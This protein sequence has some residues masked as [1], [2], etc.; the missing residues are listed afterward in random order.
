MAFNATATRILGS[1]LCILLVMGSGVAQLVDD[2]RAGACRV[3]DQQVLFTTGE[4]V[5]YLRQAQPG[6]VRLLE[7]SGDGSRV[8]QS[9][10]EY[11]DGHLENV[12]RYENKVWTL[13]DKSGGQP[14]PDW[15]SL[16]KR[17]LHKEAVVYFY[18]CQAGYYDHS[19][20][21]ERELG[22]GIAQAFSAEF[23]VTT[24]GCPEFVFYPGRFPD[25]GGRLFSN[26]SE[27]PSEGHSTPGGLWNVFKDGKRYKPLKS[28]WVT[29]FK[30]LPPPRMPGQTEKI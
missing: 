22:W 14:A 28:D 2:E 17:A 23:G 26:P 21:M 8:Y 18:G 6:S 16:L 27:P 4:L 3:N 12:L 9:L 29:T 30:G 25:P 11:P 7:F 1:L 15:V 13:T 19:G 20:L 24:I 10:D 5:D